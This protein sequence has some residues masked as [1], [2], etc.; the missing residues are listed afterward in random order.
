M[1]SEPL[2]PLPPDVEALLALERDAHPEDTAL[3]TEV[4]ER[5]ETA[6]A[7]APTPAPAPSP[8][9]SP[10][11]AALAAV[12]A[13]KLVALALAAFAV[14]GVAGAATTAVVYENRARR[15]DPVPVVEPAVRALPTQSAAPLPL[16][17][18]PPLASPSTTASMHDTAPT[19]PKRGDLVRER[20]LLDVARAALARGRTTDAIAAA[21]EHA[22]KWP[23][24]Y[25]AEEREVVLV[26]ALVAAGRKP[27]A[28]ARTSQ[29][30]KDFPRS[31]LVP[32]LD[33][34]LDAG[35]P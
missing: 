19:A 25:L 33:V 3:K 16:T 29:F 9:P 35:V 2:S 15:P 32:A 6:V 11:A 14:G 5:V 28:E 26:Q 34:A 4:L 30:R 13:K 27:E 23:H 31:M 7:L 10:V 1:S 20:E 22:A 8:A 12:H 24:G 21:E 18:A 17:P